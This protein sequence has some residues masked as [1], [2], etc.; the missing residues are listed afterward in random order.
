MSV[1]SKVSAKQH[2][3]AIELSLN[4]TREIISMNFTP[5]WLELHV[6]EIKKERK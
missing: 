5:C 3:V 6:L 1:E 2:V 4:D